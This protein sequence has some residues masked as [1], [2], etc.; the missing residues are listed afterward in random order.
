M[1]TLRS[2]LSGRR[3]HWIWSYQ[4]EVS[5]QTLDSPERDR[6]NTVFCRSLECLLSSATT[7]DDG[8]IVPRDLLV[9]PDEATP[10]HRCGF[11]T[12]CRILNRINSYG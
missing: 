3:K 9:V 5:T 4:R 1:A 7:V 10:Y 12:A 2:E 6:R 8:M 11:W